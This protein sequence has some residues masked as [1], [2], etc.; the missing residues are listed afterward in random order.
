MADTKQDEMSM[1]EILS[2]IKDILS[3]EPEKKTAE[4]AQDVG[5]ENASTSDLHFSVNEDQNDDILDLTSDMRVDQ[6]P[7]DNSEPI[8][9]L[10]VDN[11]L[12][13]QT[14]TLDNIA[15]DSVAVDNDILDLTPDQIVHTP[16]DDVITFDE[17]KPNSQENIE[18]TSSFEDISVDD[19]PGAVAIDDFDLDSAIQENEKITPQDELSVNEPMT[20]MV[21]ETKTV[22]EPMTSSAQETLEVQQPISAPVQA[23][24]LEPEPEPLVT[25]NDQDYSLVAT[26]ETDDFDLQNELETKGDDFNL[27]DAGDESAEIINNFQKI[28]ANAPS[29]PKEKVENNTTADAQLTPKIGADT[30]LIDLVKNSVDKV[31]STWVE[32]NMT[33]GLVNQE[34]TKQHDAWMEANMP[35]LLEEL[36]KKEVERVMAKAA[37]N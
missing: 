27:D 30:T 19:L 36:V 26:E 3:E 31:I 17:D 22:P 34:I 7:I 16:I 28:F 21:Q 11:T 33:I 24:H 29:A 18:D 14:T 32:E 13:N 35:K 1:D 15:E 4:F 37:K 9:E 20:A 8:D 2:S 23:T 10:I 25:P 5:A 12:Q 6:E